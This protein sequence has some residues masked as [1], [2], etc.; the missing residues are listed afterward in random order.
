MQH[1]H[2]HGACEGDAICGVVE[3]PL[4]CDKQAVN[5]PVRLLLAM[6]IYQ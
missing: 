6:V 4:H 5:C 3:V 1:P 2:L